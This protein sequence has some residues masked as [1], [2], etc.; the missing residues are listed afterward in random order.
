MYIGDIIG[1]FVVCALIM[2][3]AGYLA[4]GYFP[5]FGRWFSAR[6]LAPRY[7]KAHGV[8]RQNPSTAV[9]IEHE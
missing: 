5:R 2:L 9:D 6:W 8:R 3:P 4:R 1:M 7:L